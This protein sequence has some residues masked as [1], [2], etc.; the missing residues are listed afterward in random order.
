MAGFHNIL[1]KC[2]RA[3]AAYI[4]AKGVGTIGDVFPAKGSAN[5]ESPCTICWSERFEE[6]GPYSG[7]FTV[8]ASVMVRTQA[9]VDAGQDPLDPKIASEDRTAATF[10]L[11]YTNVDSAGDK[12]AQDITNAA[13]ES[14]LSNNGDLEDFTALN[15]S[16]KGGEA[17][18]DER[19]HG[20]TWVDTL[21]LEIACAAA[22]VS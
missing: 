7:S 2:D 3:L 17:A 18:F 10:D 20:S 11:F 4:I 15:V 1:S 12:L 5:K 14:E 9:A 21:N 16:V 6:L 19:N 13:R 8:H 22:N